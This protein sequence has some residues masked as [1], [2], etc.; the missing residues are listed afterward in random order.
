MDEVC[1]YSSVTFF[2]EFICC[3]CEPSSQN[4]WILRIGPNNV[5]FIGV[6]SGKT[7][8]YMGATYARESPRL[9]C[10]WWEWEPFSL[11]NL[12]EESG[13]RFV[14][15]PF[16]PHRRLMADVFTIRRRGKGVTKWRPTW[17][18]RKI[19]TKVKIWEG[20]VM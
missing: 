4:D 1:G 8:L 15:Q 9:P 10:Y 2:H 11:G 16:L 17:G 18:R 5:T 14:V 7:V 13:F 6:S 3:P 20:L 12:N 19:R